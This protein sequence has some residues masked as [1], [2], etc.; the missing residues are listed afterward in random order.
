MVSLG[1]NRRCSWAG[2]KPIYIKYH[3]E[4]WG[5]P[6]HDD[7][8]FFEFLSL[9]GQ[10]AGLSWIT[11]LN[12]RKVSKMSDSEIEGILLNKSIIRN[13]L[14]LYSIRNNAIIFLRIQK[15]YGSFNDYIWSFVNGKTIH[16][17]LLNTNDIQTKNEISDKM[18]KDLKQKGFKFVGTTICYAFM[19]ATGLL[20]DHSKSCF[21]YDEIKIL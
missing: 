12:K 9:E 11:V 3:D 10:Q 18:S 16:N 7:Q 5:V 4:E 1:L 8:K 6:V 13:K 2:D 14:K 17:K 19:Q 21:R 15:E 20:N